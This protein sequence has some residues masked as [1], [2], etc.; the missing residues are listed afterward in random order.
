MIKNL[1]NKER[2]FIL[3]HN[4]IGQLAYIPKGTLRNSHYLF[5]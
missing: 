1:D 3:K 4:Y 5:L 2:V